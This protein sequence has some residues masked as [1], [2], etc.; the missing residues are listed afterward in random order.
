[1]PKLP[2]FE[3][4]G[5]ITPPITAKNIITVGA[6]NSDDDEVTEFSS[7]G[8]TKDG[9]LKPDVVAAGCEKGGDHT[10]IST[11]QPDG[12][13]GM[14]GTSMAAP[15]T[16]GAIALMIQRHAK[17][18]AGTLMPSSYKA[19]IIHTALDLGTPGPD[20]RTGFGKLAVKPAIELIGE[21]KVTESHIETTNQ[22]KA[23]L[24]TVPANMRE[25]KASLV[26]D[27]APGSPAST[28]ALVNDLDL[29]L[30]SPSGKVHLPLALD[31]RRPAEPARPAADRINVME[32]V[33]VR[34]PEPGAWKVQVRGFAVPL[35][36]QDF[37]LAV[38]FR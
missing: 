33:V 7:W 28:I 20:Y 24:L 32:Q 37:S 14:C 17:L 4:F 26:W 22:A 5:N 11:I 1:L 12:Y 27:D 21:R 19:V 6:I 31:P 34:E 38:S 13:S 29:Q 10:I 16:S 15:A 35:P 30:T 3:S 36:P 2:P 8:P 23:A 9:R 25:L 18:N